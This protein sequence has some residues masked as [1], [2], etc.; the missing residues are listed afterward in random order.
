M[1]NTRGHI[2]QLSILYYWVLNTFINKTMRKNSYKHIR[3][4]FIH[5]NV[6]L[7]FDHVWEII[8]VMEITI[9]ECILRVRL[10]SPSE[11]LGWLR[12]EMPVS[13]CG[14][15]LLPL[16]GA[17]YILKN[18]MVGNYNIAEKWED[19]LWMLWKA[20]SLQDKVFRGWARGTILTETSRQLLYWN[21][22]STWYL[23]VLG[24]IY[25]FELYYKV[26]III[27]KRW[28]GRKWHFD[29]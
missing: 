11:S 15:V 27:N 7:D 21:K 23:S 12:D 9:L 16:V 4:H 6:L 25:S 5:Y 28:R 13:Q 8:I 10:P 26:L 2:Y 24:K 20:R 3:A 14:T 19:G 29:I 22:I 17:T 18:R 1:L